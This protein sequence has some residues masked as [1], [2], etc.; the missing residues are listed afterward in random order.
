MTTLIASG[1]G[2]TGRRVAQLLANDQRPVRLGSRRATPRFEW[3]DPSTWDAVLEGCDSAYVTFQPD[4][5]L[6]GAAEV[7]AAFARA[8]V[9]AGCD[10]LVLLSGRGEDGARRAEDAVRDSGAALTVV[11]SAFFVQNFTESFWAEEL[12][13]GALTITADPAPEPFVDADD[14]AEVVVAVLASTETAGLTLEVTGPRL[15]TFAEVADVAAGVSSRDV[16]YAELPV[17]DYLAALVGAGLPQPDAAGLAYLFAD[18]LD[19]RNAHVTTTV[20]EVLGREARDPVD[21]LQAGLTQVL[22]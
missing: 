9:A 18:V 12:A 14:V 8:A 1:T 17:E 6:P 19:G 2:K 22:V 5:G 10:R 16:A 4:L 7:L 20:R 13:A 3:T 21:V 11:R 15:M